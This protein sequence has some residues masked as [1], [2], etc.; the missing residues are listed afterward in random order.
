[1]LCKEFISVLST[2]QY[3]QLHSVG[4]K[5]NFLVFSLVVYT[6]TSRLLVNA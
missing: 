6:V 3:P 5:Q 2:T 1:M 4:R